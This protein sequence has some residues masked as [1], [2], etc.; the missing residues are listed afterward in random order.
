[1]DCAQQRSTLRE[2]RLVTGERLATNVAQDQTRTSGVLS[3][4][5]ERFD[6]GHWNAAPCEQFEN[7][8]LT[9]E[10]VFVGHLEKHHRATT[11]RP[12]DLIA[13]ERR[14]FTNV[15]DSDA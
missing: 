9:L 5:V 2:H 10:I 8:D 15:V 6:H 3:G 4:E 12:K 14:N 13:S 1:M 11:L 7:S